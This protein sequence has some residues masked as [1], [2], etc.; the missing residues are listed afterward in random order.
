M[1]RSGR[2]PFRP[3]RPRRARAMHDFFLRKFMKSRAQPPRGSYAA[4]PFRST[5]QY[6]HWTSAGAAARKG[7]DQPQTTL[8][9][10]SI[11]ACSLEAAA[12]EPDRPRRRVRVP[13]AERP[14]AEEQRVRPFCAATVQAMSNKNHRRSFAFA[15]NPDE[16]AVCR[17]QL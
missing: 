6:S 11:A 1:V 2:G 12:V 7:R 16:Q 9:A 4:V 3:G 8:H 10:A 13:C 14:T 15:A 5:R 17:A